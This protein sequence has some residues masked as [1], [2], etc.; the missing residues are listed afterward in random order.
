MHREKTRSIEQLDTQLSIRI[1]MDQQLVD[2]VR[3]GGY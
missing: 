1:E 2:E 3:A